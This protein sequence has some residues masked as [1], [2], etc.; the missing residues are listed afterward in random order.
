MAWN[1]KRDQASLVTSM[2]RVYHFEGWVAEIKTKRTCGLS[3]S[4]GELY[5]TKVDSGFSAS[6]QWSYWEISFPGKGKSKYTHV[7][8]YYYMYYY[9]YSYGIVGILRCYFDSVTARI[10]GIDGYL[11]GCRIDGIMEY[12]EEQDSQ[13][14]SKRGSHQQVPPSKTLIMVSIPA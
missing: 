14:Y 8:V 2:R 12:V 9:Y 3:A 1:W 4:W 5:R 6:D 7:H 11:Q 13:L 10:Q